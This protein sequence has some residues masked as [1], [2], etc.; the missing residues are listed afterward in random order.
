MDESHRNQEI[1][2]LL[3]IWEWCSRT[4]HVKW[5]RKNKNRNRCLMALA[6]AA[7]E[8]K[9]MNP[10]KLLRVYKTLPSPLL[11]RKRV[12]TFWEVQPVPLL[13]LCLGVFTK[14][15]PLKAKF[16]A[17]RESKSHNRDLD[18]IAKKMRAREKRFSSSWYF[19]GHHPESEFACLKMG[20]ASLCDQLKDLTLDNH[21]IVGKRY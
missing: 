20:T 9:L 14:T 4:L 8:P 15:S 1:G 16:E 17:I 3:D 19:Q 2:D 12:R 11:N 10:F 18:K 5:R 21:A 6:Y 13:E 7:S